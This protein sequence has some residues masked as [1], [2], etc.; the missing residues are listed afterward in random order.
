MSLA[1]AQGHLQEWQ[2]ALAAASSGSSYSIAGRTLTRQ[3]VGVIRGELQKWHNTICTIEQA[4]AG[5]ERPLGATASF[6][7]PGRGTSSSGVI[8]PDSAWRSGWS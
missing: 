6:P 3:D 7:A 8:Y 1:E 4:Q 5:N 2:A